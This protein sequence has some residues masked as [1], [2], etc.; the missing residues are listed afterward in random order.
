MIRNT[1]NARGDCQNENAHHHGRQQALRHGERQGRRQKLVDRPDKGIDA[2]RER[3]CRD[4]QAQ[5]TPRTRSNPH[6]PPLRH[7][8]ANTG[9]S[10]T[11]DEEDQ[12]EDDEQRF[13]YRRNVR[14]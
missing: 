2:R 1:L 10:Q 14:P 8:G 9:R 5:N 11:M 4:Q 3:C 13:Q 12:T 7:V 6:E